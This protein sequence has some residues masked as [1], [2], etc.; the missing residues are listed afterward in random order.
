MA[1]DKKGAPKSNSV[2]RSKLTNKGYLEQ[3]RLARLAEL[4]NTDNLS[5]THTK[6]ARS[7]SV[8]EFSRVA[9]VEL[10]TFIS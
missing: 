3:L 5:L 10:A 9:L 8:H 1:K 6:A 2:E 7:G 4:I